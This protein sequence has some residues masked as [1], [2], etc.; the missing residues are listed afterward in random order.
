M[1][2]DQHSVLHKIDETRYLLDTLKII[3]QHKHKF[4]LHCVF[5]LFS[6]EIQD[7]ESCVND[8]GVP[9]HAE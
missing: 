7:L 5:R 3:E 8:E 1:N 6:E 2:W 4:Y 9:V